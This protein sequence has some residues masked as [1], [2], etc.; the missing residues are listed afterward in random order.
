MMV[1][2]RFL[3]TGKRLRK[4]KNMAILPP[5][6]HSRYYRVVMQTAGGVRIWRKECWRHEECSGYAT[7]FAFGRFYCLEHAIEAHMNTYT[8]EPEHDLPAF[9]PDTLS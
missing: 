4:V 6:E 3:Q 1:G 9:V 8:D 7:M 2:K 5:D